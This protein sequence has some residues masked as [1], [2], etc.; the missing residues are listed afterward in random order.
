MPMHQ[1][2]PIVSVH[3]EAIAPAFDLPRVVAGIGTI[4]SH[5][6]VAVNAVD[7]A[8]KEDRCVLDLYRIPEHRPFPSLS[9]SSPRFVSHLRAQFG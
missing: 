5:P 7:L 9:M 8:A 4:R 1:I 3:L 6:G 2:P